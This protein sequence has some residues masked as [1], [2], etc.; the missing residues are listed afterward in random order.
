[1]EI[2]LFILVFTISRFFLKSA[3]RNN[4]IIRRYK[5]LGVFYLGNFV[6]NMI[7]MAL[8]R[9]NHTENFKEKYAHVKKAN[10]KFGFEIAFGKPLFFVTDLELIKQITIQNFDNFS[11]SFNVTSYTNSDDI[12]KNVIISYLGPNWR[13]F[14]SKIWSVSSTSKINRVFHIMNASAVKWVKYLK[15]KS[16]EGNNVHMEDG[17][18][19]FVI[20]FVSLSAFG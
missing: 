12:F 15:I 3:E 16:N 14:R 13:V 11:H 9:K 8:K 7:G 17:C 19:K 2:I 4:R 1:M 20:D 6:G 10:Q 18:T 5:A